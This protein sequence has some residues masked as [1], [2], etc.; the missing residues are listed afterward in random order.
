MNRLL[1]S[2]LA[3]SLFC[4]ISVFAD[5][6]KIPELIEAVRIPDFTIPV[7]GKEKTFRLPQLPPKAGMV[8][9]LRC[10]MSSFGG[11]GCNKCVRVT[12][13]DTPLGMI[14]ASGRPRLLFRELTFTLPKE[15]GKRQFNTFHG[16]N[17]NLPFAADCDDADRRVGDG[18]GSYFVL[19]L[20]DTANPVDVN[21]I[22]F[23]NIRA[24]L[25][26]NNTL[27]VQDVSIGYL[28]FSALPKSTFKPIV[29]PKKSARSITS[30]G[31]AVN[32]YNNGGFSVSFADSQTLAVETAMG[33]KL[34]TA[35]TLAASLKKPSIPLSTK[36]IDKNT[37]KIEAR[38]NNKIA[39][40]RYLRILP[41]GRVGWTD[42]WKNVSKEILAIPFRYR[43]GLANT[44]SLNWLGGTKEVLQ[45]EFSNNH[46]IF[47]EDANK[48][49]TGVAFSLE[50]DQ[51]RLILN[52]VANN[53]L[54]E[55]FSPVLALPP[56]KEF[57]CHYKL[58]SVKS[59]GYWSFINSL[60]EMRGLNK[61]GLDAPFF[62]APVPPHIN[63]KNIDERIVANL[64]SMG[65]IYVCITPWFGNLGRSVM[66]KKLPAGASYT[67]EYFRQ[68][69]AERNQISD[70]LKQYKRLLPEAK[71]MCLH[72]P[73]MLTTYMP[74]FERNPLAITAIRNADGSAYYHEGYN[75]LILKE[76]RKEGWSI[77]YYL[78]KPGN[79]WYNMVMEEVDYAIASGAD[80]IYFDEFSFQTPRHYRR[81]DYS[82]WDGFSAD[83]DENGKIIALKSDNA[84]TTDLFKQAL[85]QKLTSQGKTFLG[86]GGECSLTI[87]CSAGYA[88]VEGTSLINMPII[89]LY[90]VP[91]VLGNFGDENSKK[92]VFQG[93]RE[94]L[95]MGGL[96]TPHA[97][98]NRF[99]YGRNNFICKMYPITISE[100]GPGFIAGK[101]RFITRSSGTFTWKGVDN[102]DVK[103]YIYDETGDRIKAGSKGKVVNGKITL[104][105]PENGLVI[106]ELP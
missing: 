52:A 64:G 36:L 22:S 89:H 7:P 51:S 97:G 48:I 21:T 81:Y 76:K 34:G 88:F 43:T 87:N 46:T 63:G 90:N 58:H 106:A 56:G 103:L 84:R 86:N 6:K 74:E 14:T 71:I 25:P 32:V 4:T 44:E 94:A 12:L 60:R 41:D 50:D 53:G 68:R 10:R 92:G 37:I 19:D 23:R 102:A 105:V 18:L 62:W 3:V 33:M 47:Y 40:T 28:P 45:M 85:L 57:T 75:E 55:M 78:P 24:N 83:I 16:A 96:Y 72:H 35:P 29:P 104:T 69:I 91:L 59:G 39:L 99:L 27:T 13:N 66:H 93:A 73:A 15:Y 65:K 30:G 1:K 49:G 38:W 31:T 67:E 42:I 79:P 101:E 54:I 17:I 2:L 5:G 20:T 77:I 11:G 26:G 80:G 100:I 70:K 8:I 98:S 9:V 82:A 95:K 61:R